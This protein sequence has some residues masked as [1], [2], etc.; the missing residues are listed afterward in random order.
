MVGAKEGLEPTKQVKTLELKRFAIAGADKVWHW[1]QA[2]ID[3]D[4]QTVLVSSPEVPKPV[5]V[6]YAYSMNPEGSNLYNKEGLPASPFRT[7]TW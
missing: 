1:A 7:D 3:R 4:H 2:K 5:A 6:R